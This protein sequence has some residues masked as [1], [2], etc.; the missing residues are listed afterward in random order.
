MTLVA[1]HE[2]LLQT[3]KKDCPLER[4]KVSLWPFSINFSSAIFYDVLTLA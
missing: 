2:T 1:S 4:D 3:P